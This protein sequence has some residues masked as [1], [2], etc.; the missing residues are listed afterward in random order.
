MSTKLS[1]LGGALG[2]FY[3]VDN[4][5]L[6][7]RVCSLHGTLREAQR[8]TLNETD[9]LAFDAGATYTAPPQGEA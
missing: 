9:A 2:P 4:S 3:L 6:C 5:G 1:I 8:A 7:P